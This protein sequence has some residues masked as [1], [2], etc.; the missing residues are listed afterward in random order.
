MTTPEKSR[1]IADQFEKS[2]DEADR[3]V[4]EVLRDLANQV[5]RLEAQRKELREALE[6][7][8][9]TIPPYKENGECT[10]SDA[11]IQL[12]NATLKATE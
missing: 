4:S 5:E 2:D 7:M 3:F 10:I 8:L 1:W 9:E 11:T 6:L 12:V